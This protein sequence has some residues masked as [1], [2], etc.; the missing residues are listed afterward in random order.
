MV[1]FLVTCIILAIVLIVQAAIAALAYILWS[2]FEAA[3]DCYV[4]YG[5]CH[6]INSEGETI[7]IE[8][9]W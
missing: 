4:R 8:R 2:L 9:K 6:C 7:V 1:F 5:L 3:V